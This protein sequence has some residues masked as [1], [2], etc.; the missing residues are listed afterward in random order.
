MCCTSLWSKDTLP[1]FNSQHSFKIN[2]YS[3]KKMEFEIIFQLYIRSLSVFMIQ[4]SNSAI[5]F[6]LLSEIFS[7]VF[8]WLI[9]Q[10]F[11]K[12][13]SVNSGQIKGCEVT[14]VVLWTNAV[15]TV[16]RTCKKWGSYEVNRK[17][18]WNCSLFPTDATLQA[19]YDTVII[20]IANVLMSSTL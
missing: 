16:D 1:A 17:L 18:Q 8:L 20:S 4:N 5:L 6:S 14:D 19:C 10:K 2:F 9:F 3:W 15:D 7:V 13:K 12:D 11:P